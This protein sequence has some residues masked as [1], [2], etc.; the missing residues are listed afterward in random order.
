MERQLS[1]YE[2]LGIDPH[3]AGVSEI[4]KALLPKGRYK[5]A[6]CIITPDPQIKGNVRVKHPDGSGSKT[7]E[8]VL[9]FLE[10]GDASIFRDE[11]YDFTSMNTSDIAACGFVY[12][13]E[14][15]DIIDI[16]PLRLPQKTEILREIAIGFAELLEL[17]Q[18]HKIRLELLGGE[19]ADL[20][21]QTNTIV[22]NADVRSSMPENLLISGNVQPG[23]IHYGFSSAGKAIWEKLINSGLMANGVT[24]GR[25]VTMHHSYSKK[26]PFLCHPDKP[27]SGRF[28][29]GDHIP[30]LGM[31]IDQAILSPT[32]QWAI[33]IRILID[34]L[35]SLG[36]LHLLHGICVNTGGG[37]TKSL[38]LG[39][40]IRY[41][42]NIPAPSAI[43]QLIQSECGETWNNM[44]T[45][46]NCGIGLEIIGSDEGGILRKAIQKVSTV[47]EVEA[48]FLGNCEASTSGKN[49]V[50]IESLY[51]TFPP[52][53]K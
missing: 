40:D 7:D 50:I 52:F 17:Y 33:L 37:L 12:D 53:T 31:T 1:M 5:N 27:F 3:K 35:S 16:N 49:E 11:P 23:D 21:D 41:V 13:V 39:K 45:T 14:L 8:R 15:T 32:R 22:T 25:K 19:T 6:F 43:F 36:A 38:N 10:T 24:M 47:T 34:E 44:F 2:K 42:K 30:E 46:F 51:G 18:E 4:F 28:M 20:T 9:Y 29:I 26:Y 48:H